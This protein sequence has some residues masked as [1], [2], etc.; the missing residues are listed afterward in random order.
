M[1]S[2][3]I[4][5]AG[6]SGLICAVIA[7]RN[8]ADVTLF[9]RNSKIGKKI[10][11]TGNGRCNFTNTEIDVKKYYG[12]NPDF[13]KNALFKFS[14][15]DAID[16]FESI[17]I[18]PVFS[19]NGK[20]SPRSLQASSVVELFKYEI[21]KLNISLK[22]E[23]FIQN[24]E[25][26]D[27]K[28]I[29]TDQS[30]I[31]YTGE[32]V[33]LATGGKAMPE[34]GSDGNGYKLCEKFNHYVTNIFPSLVQLHLAGNFFKKISGVKIVARASLMED[35]RVLYSEI[36]DV[37]FTDYGISG[38]PILQISRLA[39]KMLFEKK[40]PVIS[41]DL[42]NDMS[43]EELFSK[44]KE[45]SIYAYGKSVFISMIGFLHK[46]LI[47]SILDES[48]VK[49]LN[50]NAEDLKDG[51]YRKIAN[52]LKNWKMRVIADNGFKFA[53]V[54]A[55]GIKTDEINPKTMESKKVNGLYFAG[56]IMDVDGM[57]GG[58]NLHWAWTSG[59]IAGNSV[60]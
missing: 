53:Q 31:R 24:I 18:S 38:P 35:D 58:Y 51:D 19:E 34:S 39:G 1:M 2:V 9:E 46:R 3:L 27:D 15:D 13:I 52:V 16:F 8:G 57:C 59:Y 60:K 4:I 17:G 45:R 55:G 40:A 43:E 21:E 6:A 14:T 29:L 37:L 11:S 41:L 48:G 47:S 26:V 23:T 10:A 36:G 44:L 56:E 50:K 22:L 12:E 7:A 30:G 32:T 5:G 28:F 49:Y 20:V 25:K 33:I 54:T 42:M